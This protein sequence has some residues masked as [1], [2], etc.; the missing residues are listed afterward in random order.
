VAQTAV[1]N[2]APSYHEIPEHIYNG[3][4]DAIKIFC[5]LPPGPTSTPVAIPTDGKATIVFVTESVPIESGSK[6]ETVTMSYD[7]MVPKP[8]CSTGPLDLI[9]LQG[10][11]D[12]QKTVCVDPDG[13]YQ[14]A[15]TISGKLNA[16]PMDVTQSPPVPC[17]DPF[18]AI[19]SDEQRGIL[20]GDFA[21][22]TFDSKRIA[23][24]NRGTE[25]LITKLHMSSTG[26]N[27]FQT[28]MQCLG[29][30]R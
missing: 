16:V 26:R 18:F 7:Q 30:D 22:V 5:D 29:A 10:T 19:V 11:V 28:R 1:I 2:D 24:G 15:S 13:R 9:Y 25:K 21:R 3:V 8:L 17:G 23:P 6:T 14:Y 20:D 4:P 12:I 27:L